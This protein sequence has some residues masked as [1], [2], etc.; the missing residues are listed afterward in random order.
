[1][2]MSIFMNKQWQSKRD[3]LKMIYIFTALYCEAQV[4]IKHFNLEK[5][6]G[7]TRFQQFYNDKSGIILTITGVGEIAAASAVCSVCTECGPKEGDVLFNIGICAHAKGKNG[8]FLCN[9]IVEYSTGKT[10]YPDILYR[11]EFEEE[12]IV[13]GM[14]PFDGNDIGAETNNA[15]DFFPLN[16]GNGYMGLTNVTSFENLYDMEAAAIY[17]SGSYFL[18]PHQMV[19]LK[20]VSDGGVQKEVSAKR[21][22][23]LM[24]TY[25]EDVCGFIMQ[26][27]KEEFMNGQKG[28]GFLNKKEK[29]AEKLC[30]DLHCSKVME[31]LLRQHIR[32]L[33]LEGVDYVS[34][35]QEMYG[36]G[37]LPC[38]DKRGGKIIFEE[39]KRRL[40]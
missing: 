29:I 5:N 19:F 17:Q 15:S 2:N 9:K 6:L 33:E 20:V 13:T 35:I 32:Y 28:D 27:L 3:G 8:I 25:K 37:L 16:D 40:F 21:T 30:R 1:M 34:V 4:F 39:F 24:E 38:K 26:L 14:L 18:G 10:F 23:N 31:D 36:E 11:H 12:V 22:V 7:N